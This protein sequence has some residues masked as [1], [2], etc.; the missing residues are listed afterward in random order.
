[1]RLAG[2]CKRF[3]ASVS[4]VVLVA[5]LCLVGCRSREESKPR[6]SSRLKPLAILY[7]QY[8]GQHGGKAPADEAALKEFIASQGT[9]LKSFGV[10]DAASLF[11][12][13]RDGQP[14]VVL[15]GSAAT[16]KP[17]VAYEQTGVDGWRYVGD[18][19]GAVQEVDEARFRQLVPASP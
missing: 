6:E 10:T 15:Y 19:L 9:M 8:V 13:E 3:V 18:T 7:G 5:T 4:W 17:I 1:M 12:S 2:T 16:G 11:V 14:Y